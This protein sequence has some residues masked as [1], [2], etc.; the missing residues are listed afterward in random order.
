MGTI[1]LQAPPDRTWSA[2]SNLSDP[3]APADDELVNLVIP[4]KHIKN[5]SPLAEEQR[6]LLEDDVSVTPLPPF[7]TLT[8]R[9]LVLVLL[10]SLLGSSVLTMPVCFRLCGVVM[11]ECPSY[12]VLRFNILLGGQ[13]LFESIQFP[14]CIQN[15]YW[16]TFKAVSWHTFLSRR[17]KVLIVLLLSLRLLH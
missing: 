13:C 12:T 3:D 11:G 1:E 15:C 9:D 8:Q 4:D 6:L 7:N 14:T 17:A 5:L 16:L 2:K 10:N